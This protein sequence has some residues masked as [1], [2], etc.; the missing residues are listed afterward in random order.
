M[1]RP[2]SPQIPSQGEE[3]NVGLTV[4]M[5]VRITQQI[6]ARHYAFNAP[7][8]GTVVDIEHRPTG[9]WFAH[10][11]DDKL[12]LSRVVLRKDDGEISTLNLD[13][14]SQIERLS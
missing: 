9:S 4:G 7:V 10:G 5:R 1:L 14:H 12:W 6:A 8:E 11:V 3:S 13:E 2:M